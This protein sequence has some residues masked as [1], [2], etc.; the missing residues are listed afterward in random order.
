MDGL[1]INPLGSHELYE[2]KLYKMLNYKAF[3]YIMDFVED[4]NTINPNPTK[5][6]KLFHR[7]ITNVLFKDDQLIADILKA[8][9]LFTASIDDA[10]SNKLPMSQWG[11]LRIDLSSSIYLD[12]EKYVD[13]EHAGSI[14]KYMHIIVSAIHNDDDNG[15]SPMMNALQPMMS[16]MTSLLGTMM[17]SPDLGNILNDGPP[18]EFVQNV[19]NSPMIGNMMNQFGALL[20]GSGLDA[21]AMSAMLTGAMDVKRLPDA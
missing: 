13:T 19:L 12:L 15:S 9:D 14:E 8:F 10:L 6:D 5:S 21:G 7:A 2:N 4:L 1:A 20:Q 18:E 17:N 16:T 3:R 11:Y